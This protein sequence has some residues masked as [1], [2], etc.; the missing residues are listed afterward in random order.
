MAAY[1]LYKYNLRVADAMC[2][3]QYM[4]FLLAAWMR[5]RLHRLVNFPE[6]PDFPYRGWDCYAQAIWETTRLPRFYDDPEFMHSSSEDSSETDTGS[7]N[8]ERTLRLQNC[9]PPDVSQ[10]G[11]QY[12]SDEDGD[13]P[14]LEK[15]TFLEAWQSI[16][17]WIR[18]NRRASS[19]IVAHDM[20]AAQYLYILKVAFMRLHFKKLVREEDS[21]II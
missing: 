5:W 18:Q 3:S 15:A 12:S 1:S 11:R 14:S 7:N 21:G 13:G 2:R 6:D 8:S 9:E 19:L 20:G 16:A 17:M 4:Y 10:H